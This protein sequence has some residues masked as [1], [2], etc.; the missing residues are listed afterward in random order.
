MSELKTRTVIWCAEQ[1]SGD[2]KPVTTTSDSL[3]WS[4]L[5]QKEM[6]GGEGTWS[7]KAPFPPFT[8][9]LWYTLHCSYRGML[10]KPPGPVPNLQLPFWRVCSSLAFS[11]N[12][13][14]TGCFQI[15]HYGLKPR[16]CF[17]MENPSQPQ[18]IGNLV[19]IQVLLCSSAFHIVLPSLF[20]CT[21]LKVR[22]L[23]SPSFL[24][25]CT[26]PCFAIRCVLPLRLPTRREASH[27]GEKRA[28]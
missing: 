12:A 16:E 8:H 28:L 11:R 18:R 10:C 23:L 2:P 24:L 25:F 6:K 17:W 3:C 21:E 9:F 14:Y 7:F 13:S 26:V 20:F 22:F 19:D 27:I 5:G 1:Y 4:V 15:L